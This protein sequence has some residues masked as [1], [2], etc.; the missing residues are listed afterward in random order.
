MSLFGY[1]NFQQNFQNI[2]R[3]LFASAAASIFYHI[4]SCTC[5]GL[6]NLEVKKTINNVTVQLF[7]MATSMFLCKQQDTALIKTFSCHKFDQNA[8]NGML[9]FYSPDNL[10]RIANAQTFFIDGT[11]SV[12][13][14]PCKQLYTIR[15]PFKDVTVTAV[16]AFL[17]NKCQD[18]YKELFQSIVDNCHASNLQLN[19][20]TIITDFE[21]AVIRAVTAVF[22]R[23]IDYQGCF[24]H[25]TQASWRKIQQLGLV[26]QPTISLEMPVPSQGHY[27]FHSF[28]V[29]D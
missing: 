14:H 29:V 15:V 16:Y 7:K 6:F 17:P 23:H 10:E 9:V 27:G 26:P 22:G 13:Q 25:L 18:T 21:D 2:D 5:S 3:N 28:P 12:A 24:Y 19:V 20:Q 1:E 4:V 8:E 11:F